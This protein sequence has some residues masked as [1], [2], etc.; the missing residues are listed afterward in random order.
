MSKKKYRFFLQRYP[1]AQGEYKREDIERTYRCKYKQFSGLAFD[2]AVKNTYTEDYA[3]QDG[4]RIHIPAK[5][6]LRHSTYECKLQLLFN[7]NTCQE[8][9]RLFYEAYK[10]VRCEYNDS[11]RSI[12]ATL[13]MTKQPTVVQEKLYSSTKYQLVE[14][15]FTNIGGTVSS[16]SRIDF[17]PSDGIIYRIDLTTDGTNL[18]L[19]GFDNVPVNQYICLLTEG[20]AR[21]RS[22]KSKKY[23]RSSYRWHVSNPKMRFFIRSTE[24]KSLKVRYPSPDD[25]DT[26]LTADP[27][28]YF[29]WS[30]IESESGDKKMVIKK[31]AHSRLFFPAVKGNRGRVT[32]GI[33]IYEFLFKT[34]KRLS[35]VCYF[36]CNAEAVSLDEYG[37]VNLWTWLTV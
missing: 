26:K 34:I 18:F 32:Y 6:D 7:R 28:D 15:T 25:F 21:T 16:E 27:L 19:K 35:N 23:R 30:S 12:F 1:D 17:M 8:D 4:A 36:Q 33:A 22:R 14:F 31:A 37:N 29:E 10:G 24:D 2:G 13:L 5:A 3:E 11:F 20:A 9:S